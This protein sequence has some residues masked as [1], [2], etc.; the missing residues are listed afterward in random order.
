MSRF[1]R[2]NPEA[3]EVWRRDLPAWVDDGAGREDYGN[4][5]VEPDA[6]EDNLQASIDNGYYDDPQPAA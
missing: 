3:Y 1:A 4:D 5:E 2:E 6:D